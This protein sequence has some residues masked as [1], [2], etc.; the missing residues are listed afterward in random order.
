MSL[1]P[2]NV[3]RTTVALSAAASAL[4]PFSSLAQDGKPTSERPIVFASNREGKNKFGIFSMKMDGSEVKSLSKSDMVEV[5]PVLSPDGKQVA[6]VA[7]KTGEKPEGGIYIVNVDGKE[8]KKIADVKGLATSPVWSPD[9]K[10]IAFTSFAMDMAAPPKFSLQVMDT[11]GKN[12]KEIGEGIIS[13]WSSDGKKMLIARMEG[14][15]GF[16]PHMYMIDADGSNAKKLVDEKAMMGIFSPDGKRILFLS[17]KDQPAPGEQDQPD[18]YVMNVDGSEKKQLTKSADIEM[19]PRWS[20]DGK[21]VYFFR[22]PQNMNGDLLSS[23][24]DIYRIDADGKNE[25]PLTKDAAVNVL[26]GGAIFLAFATQGQVET[27]EKP[28]TVDKTEK[29]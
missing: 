16:E 28:A 5:D 10:R 27:I 8:R 18:I 23:K 22:F 9:G 19:S 13:D 29:P 20:A 2:R 4:F 3:F 11:D 26:T 6:F 14:G 25:K 17:G 7:M 1:K 21:H 24:V 15:M 12:K